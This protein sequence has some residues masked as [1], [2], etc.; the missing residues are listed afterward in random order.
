MKKHTRIKLHKALAVILSIALTISMIYTSSVST[1]ADEEFFDDELDDS[2]D[3]DFDEEEIPDDAKIPVKED[4]K[5]PSGGEDNYYDIAADN[6]NL[7]FGTVYRGTC[8][9]MYLPIN[10]V[11]RGNRSVDLTWYEVDHD[12]AFYVDAPDSLYVAPG[13]SIT[14]HV[15]MNMTKV[16]EFTGYLVVGS[17][18][19]YDFCNAISINLYGVVEDMSPKI[20]SVTVS[21]SDV[22]AG[23]GSS[24]QFQ[25]TVVGE[26]NPDLNVNWKVIGATD[27]ATT[28]DSTGN[29]K[30]SPNENATNLTVVATSVQDS[31]Y[32]GRAN[33][34]LSGGTYTI[35]TSVSPA[36]AGTAG[37]GGS[38][39]RGSSLSVIAAPNN[40]YEFV[41]W[42]LDGVVVSN[43]A[44][45][46]ISNI[47]KDMKL[48]ANFRPTSCYVKVTK[49]HADAG[50]VTDSTSVKYGG[51]ITLTASPNSGYR[52]DG[53]YENDKLLSDA[54]S[55]NLSNI[56]ANREIKACFSQTV[57]SVNVKASPDNCGAVSGSGNYQKGTDVLITAK[58][59]EGY[60][61]VCWTVNNNIV[62]YDSSCTIK[63]ISQDYVLV[64]NFEPKKVVN[65][66]ISATVA[67]GSGSIS[68]AGVTKVS[69]GGS[70]VI[71]FSPAEGYE[72]IAV[73]VDGKQV[74]AVSSYS[75][76]NVKANHV[77][78][79]AFGKKKPASEKSSN[80]KSSSDSSSAEKSKEDK[81]SDDKPSEPKKDIVVVTNDDDNNPT[82][83]VIE[84]DVHQDEADKANEENNVTPEQI[85]D[86]SDNFNEYVNLSGVLQDL[87]MTEAEAREF[88]RQGQ[89]LGL[90]ER[91]AKEQYLAVTVHNEYASYAKET[92][93]VGFSNL[94]TIPNLEEVIGSLL[95]EDEK[96]KVLSGEHIGINVNIFNNDDLQ[97]PEDKQIDAAAKRNGINIAQHFE[98]V[99]LKSQ[100][101]YSEVMTTLNAPMKIV[102]NVPQALID[103][104]REFY[105]VRSHVEPDGSVSISFINDE[106]SNPATIT[107][108]TDRFSSYAIGYVGGGVL[109]KNSNNI[110]IVLVAAISV[111]F[112]FVLSA[113]LIMGTRHRRYRRRK[114][115]RR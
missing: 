92:E 107:F 86:D 23:Y 82:D 21:P 68:P 36:N 37:G 106:D 67:S 101:G 40:G 83:E 79:V 57:F 91:A 74:G 114:R 84:I 11:N 66:E 100:D 59:A 93:F 26:N 30:I 81:A 70:Q 48:V 22:S 14:F 35:S 99:M 17:G 10:I 34:S 2:Y 29:L 41:N 46:E 39:S 18:D 44:R 97:T 96:I 9:M 56:T 1:L 73:A 71:C 87:N 4:E 109:T 25:S 95:T 60:N 47:K 98:M 45:Y 113:T 53:W 61:F 94:A 55:I 5:D 33:V 8:A 58:P 50:K 105:I 49:N 78:A 15:S 54:L 27:S 24:V 77:I 19:D 90:L 62:S 110:M 51:S 7:S 12:D 3:Y 88:I 72:I 89:D 102:M 112:G 52:F 6:Y 108:T 13:Q 111:I 38:V 43:S 115:A 64:A 42:T 69:E 32:E 75:F 20:T 16:G 104:G 63:N 85:D 65:Y 28:I 103:S 31:K 80:D 76:S